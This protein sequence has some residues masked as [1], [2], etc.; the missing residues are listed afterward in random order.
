MVGICVKE[1]NE[2]S[3]L[4]KLIQHSIASNGARAFMKVG[5]I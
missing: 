5:E 4:F 3:R 2:T 1:K